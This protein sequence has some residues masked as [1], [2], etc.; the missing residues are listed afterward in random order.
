M[1]K[2]NNREKA[3]SALLEAASIIEAAQKCGLS[4]KT[5]RRYLDDKEFLSEYRNARRQVVENSISQL[6]KA[7]G[8]AVET[9]KKNLHCENPSAENQAARLIIENSIKAVEVTDILERL[10]VLENAFE[11]QDQKT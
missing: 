3:L 9:L 5:L 6:Q 7:S 8:E 2:E 11:K 1:P 10:E 4:E